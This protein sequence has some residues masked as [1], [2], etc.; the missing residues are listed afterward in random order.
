MRPLPDANILI[1]LTVREHEH[2]ARVSAWLATRPGFAICS[3]VE[4]ALVRFLVRL[5]ES[6]TTAQALIDGVRARPRCEFWVEAPSY[7]D[8]DL[9]AVRGSR[10]VRDAYLVGLAGRHSS[11]VA[12]LDEALAQRYPALTV[13]LPG[14]DSA[15][16]T[17]D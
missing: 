15:P 10:Q 8:V 9:S 16:P 6:A 2:H 14:G 12:T 13:L 1:A 11:A 17:P 7:A 3:V 4:G 5:G